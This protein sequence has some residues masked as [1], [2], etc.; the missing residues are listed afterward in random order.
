VDLPVSKGA[1]NVD[2][3]LFAPGLMEHALERRRGRAIVSDVGF[4]G[5]DANA[6]ST[7]IVQQRSQRKPQGRSPGPT[8][9]P[10]PR[11]WPR[12]PIDMA[13]TRPLQLADLRP[14]A[15]PRP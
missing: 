13:D 6:S 3:S 1:R 7:S 2:A 12:A 10:W 11:G 15:L 4:V 9:H 8:D 5:V 14:A